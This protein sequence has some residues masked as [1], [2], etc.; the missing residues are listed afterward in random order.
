MHVIGDSFNDVY[1]ELAELLNDNFEFKSSPRGLDIKECLGVSFTITNPRDRGI[2]NSTRKFK[3]HYTVA[4]T[5]WYLSANDETS[6]ISYYASFWNRISDD[7]VTANSAYGAR[8]FRPHPRVG[9]GAFIQWDWVKNELIRDPDSRRAIIHIKSP[10]DSI[11]ATLDVPCTLALQFLIRDGRLH[12]VVNMRSSDLILGIANDVPAF[13]TLQEVMALE[14]G[15]ELGSYVHISNSLH[16]Y[17]KN[18]TMLDEMCNPTNIAM[19]ENVHALIG[20]HPTMPGLP[21]TDALMKYDATLRTVNNAA[22]LEE[23]TNEADLGFYWTDWA[24]MLASYRA[25]VLGHPDIAQ[26]LASNTFFVRTNNE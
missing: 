24:L 18:W 2:F 10:I 5:L 14:L 4:E 9:D 21:P 22:S 20:P 11:K 26:Q 7:G 8:I 3:P 16:V 17:K 23:I 1:N 19:S 15:L 12:L 13:T 25:K 6:W